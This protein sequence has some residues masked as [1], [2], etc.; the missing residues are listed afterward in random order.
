MPRPYTRRTIGSVTLN[1]GHK[2]RKELLKEAKRQ[3]VS[4]AAIMR[5]A[6]ENFMTKSLK[7]RSL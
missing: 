5:K 4:M 1:I 7:E 3:E 6:L 2:T